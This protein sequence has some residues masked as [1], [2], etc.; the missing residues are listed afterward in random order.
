MRRCFEC[1][2]IQHRAYLA[3][4]AGDF[5]GLG[6]YLATGIFIVPL[7]AGRNRAVRAHYYTASCRRRDRGVWQ[8]AGGYAGAQGWLG[9]LWFW[10]G[11]QGW[12]YLDLGR[13]WQILLVIG[14]FVW[15]FMLFRGLRGT[16]REEHFGNMPW[17]LFYATWRYRPSMPSAFSPVRTKVSSSMTSRVFGG[18][19]LGGGFPGAVYD[20]YRR[21]HVCLA[22]RGS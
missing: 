14:L 11:H 16:L 6:V 5:L 8:P 9:D 4:A 10:L 7:I 19:P 3:R 12:E 15:V 17:L 2:A 21:L 18:A 22:R 20:R 13:L 1:A